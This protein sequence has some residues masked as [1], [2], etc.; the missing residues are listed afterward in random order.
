MSGLSEVQF[1][2]TKFNSLVGITSNF[3]C[4]QWLLL[5]TLCYENKYSAKMDYYAHDSI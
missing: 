4:Q 5:G 1:S 3:Y 2:F